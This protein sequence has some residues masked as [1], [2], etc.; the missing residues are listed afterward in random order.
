MFLKA[1]DEK[2]KYNLKNM[3]LILKNRLA[4]RFTWQ[5]EP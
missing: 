5:N 2:Q 1:L 4:L 3:K